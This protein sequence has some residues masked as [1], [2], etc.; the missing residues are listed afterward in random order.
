MPNIKSAKKELRKG[1]KHAAYNSKITA[2]L[3]SALK[4][5]RKAIDANDPKAADL[6]KKT[7]KI[8]DKATQKGVIK[9]NN[10]GRKKSHLQLRLNKSLKK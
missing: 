9:K 10:S 3:K 6:V 5:T 4:D 1:K 2:D 8:L 7:L